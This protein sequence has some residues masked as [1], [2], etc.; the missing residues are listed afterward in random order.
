M[1]KAKYDKDKLPEPTYLLQEGKKRLWFRLPLE[2]IHF[3]SL[4]KDEQLDEII[5]FLKTSHTEAEMMR[6]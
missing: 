6:I 2:E 4:D 5:N 3:F 1:D